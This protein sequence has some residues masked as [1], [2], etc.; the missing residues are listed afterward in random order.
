MGEAS[1]VQGSPHAVGWPVAQNCPAALEAPRA[2]HRTMGVQMHPKT[3]PPHKALLYPFQPGS[4]PDTLDGILEAER[5]SPLE[6][7]TPQWL[8]MFRGMALRRLRPQLA[9]GVVK[10]ADETN[11]EACVR[12]IRERDD[13]TGRTTPCCVCGTPTIVAISDLDHIIPL[14]QNGRHHIDNLG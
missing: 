3:S 11:R 12:T 1:P 14:A 7:M 6:E 8:K 13:I 2:R 9:T 5:F 4:P 10:L